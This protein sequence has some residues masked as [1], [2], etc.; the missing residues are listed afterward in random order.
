MRL[1]RVRE[2]FDHP[3]FIFELKLD[4]FR[5]VAF[6][7][8]GRCQLVSSNGHTFDQWQPLTREI[9]ASVRCYSAIIDGEVA[10]LDPDS[11]SN[12]YNLLFRRRAPFYCA[13]DLLMLDGED[14]RSLPLLERKRRLLDILPPIEARLRYVDHIHEAGVRF[15]ELAC[16][17]DLEG[18]V[19]KYC[20]G[21]YQ[22]DTALTSWVKVKNRGYTQAEG[23][24]E[25][26]EAAALSTTTF[27][28]QDGDA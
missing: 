8:N 13:F 21:T 1:L 5:G 10:C 15:F 24:A 18:I 12:F 9:A 25:L 22:A 2:A 27:P 19:G 16:E 11:R 20:H 23:R 28:P 3:D 26:F 7:D 14:L 6:V 17:R 4:G